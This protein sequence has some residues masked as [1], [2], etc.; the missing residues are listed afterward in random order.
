MFWKAL[1]VY[2]FA[3]EI[4]RAFAG[5][6]SSGICTVPTLGGTRHGHVDQNLA[7]QVVFHRVQCRDLVSCGYGQNHNIAGG[8][9][10]AF[11]MASAGVSGLMSFSA[12]KASSA[13]SWVREPMTIL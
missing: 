12:A 5:T 11:S 3:E 2:V 10:R 1:T 4:L 7:L 6:T 9:G 13:F 8:G